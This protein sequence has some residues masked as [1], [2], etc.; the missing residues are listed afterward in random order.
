MQPG[1]SESQDIDQRI[2]D[3][4][5]SIADSLQRCHKQSAYRVANDL[6]RLARREQ[7]LVPL[8]LAQFEVVNLAQ[9]LYQHQRAREVAIE[10][11]ALLESPER[12]R[13]VQTNYEENE[14][15]QTCAW[16]TACAYDNL[17]KHTAE[18]YG[19]NSDG[20]HQCIADGI[21]VCRRTGKLRCI[22]CFREYAT[23]VY[24]AADDVAMALHHASAVAA[25]PEGDAAAERRWVGAKDKGRILALTGELPAARDGLVAA[26]RLAETFHDPLGA[27]LT[28]LAYLESVLWLLGDPGAYS[29]LAGES[30][31]Q[32]ALPAGEHASQDCMWD[33]RD[34]VAACC[35]GEFDKAIELLAPW[36]T[37]FA[38]D[39]LANAWFET[40][41]RLIAAY[42]L[43]G[44]KERAEK[45]IAPLHKRAQKSRDWL[46]L[47]RL[48]RLVDD[49]EPP[50]PTAMLASP[51]VGP[52]AAAGVSVPAAPAETPSNAEL[53]ESEA[54]EQQRSPMSDVFAQMVERLQTSEEDSTKREI[55]QQILALP[56]ADFTDPR[57]AA[58]FM[59]LLP[60]LL[61]QAAPF[62][63][64]WTWGRQAAAPFS[65]TS[66]VVNLLAT[67]GD[68]LSSWPDANMSERID[69]KHLEELF[70]QSLD[71]DA[72][73]VLNHA[74]A[75][76]FYL[77]QENAGE[78]ER[79]LARAFRL[80]RNNSNLALQLAE[81]YQRT[82]RPRDALGVLDLCLREGGADANAAWNAALIAHQVG[83]YDSSLT[84]LD[85]FE[86]LHPDQ[87]W[88]GYYRAIAHLERGQPEKALEALS[89]EEQRNS[90]RPFG[91]EILRGCAAAALG[92]RE[93][94]RE[95]FECVLAV[96]WSTIDYFTLQG[97]TSLF[98]RLWQAAACL[99]DGDEQFARLEHRLI[100]AGLAPDALFERRRLAGDTTAS[101]CY[102]RCVLRQ[103]LDDRW[104]ASPG[105]LHGQSS[106]SAYRCLWGILAQD[107]EEAE[108]L[109]LA[110]QAECY[111]LPATVE[112]VEDLKQQ[113]TDKPG[114]VWQGVRWSD[115]DT[116]S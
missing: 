18:L 47:R 48:R 45:L 52:F 63:T 66:F 39:N 9:D 108:R 85:L 91:T 3:L 94:L 8:L 84:Y 6:L 95:H 5:K 110:Q 25:L 30:P 50:T 104:A 76:A 53:A 115:D 51:R 60:Y 78:A 17:A 16:M 102:Y 116:V 68:A 82:D 12:A 1:D 42:R 69:R 38:Q 32:R 77:R 44:K 11:I 27:R 80:Q 81:I 33:Y 74:R 31:G 23:D 83:Q 49:T 61:D 70:R 103:P 28:T 72:D 13:Q 92:R 34:A 90:E 93:Q 113:Y 22:T 67:L 46:T 2:A 106:W 75:G 29:S 88:V 40:R 105:C 58:S 114:I 98:A 41:L 36:D 15:A 26:L 55:L 35:T 99:P 56:P 20:M 73:N 109:A 71:L 96:A 65:Q 111:S 101:V 10:M 107:A 64:V 79:C 97:L 100:A 54:A 87:P 57:D 24:L 37:R 112:T 7:R 14:Y 86:S 89:L 59:Y 43:A 62:D 4:K 21:E 19:L